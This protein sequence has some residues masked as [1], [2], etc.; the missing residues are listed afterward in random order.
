MYLS[1]C[2]FHPSQHPVTE[3]GVSAADAAFSADLSRSI[4]LVSPYGESVNTNI[5]VNIERARMDFE[6]RADIRADKI[7]VVNMVDG[8]G[9]SLRAI[10]DGGPRREFLAHL[11][12]AY[13]QDDELFRG[14][15]CDRLLIYNP[16]GNLTKHL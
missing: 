1:F 4:T 6:A 9:E 13:Q 15:P 3:G 2:P 11:L 8:D 5:T 12:I 16:I 7:L 14:K 10:D